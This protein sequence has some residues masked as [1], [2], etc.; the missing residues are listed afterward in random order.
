MEPFAQSDASCNSCTADGSAP[1]QRL[2]VLQVCDQ[3]HP[4]LI[5][6][7]VGHCLACD[8]EKAYEGMRVRLAHTFSSSRPAGFV[9]PG[10]DD[11]RPFAKRTLPSATHS[12]DMTLASS[13]LGQHHGAASRCS[14]LGCMV[15][16]LC[17]LGYSAMDII[18]TLFKV[19]RNQQM[20]EFLKM[21]F[22]KVCP[23]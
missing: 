8:I 6:T 15:Q 19:V 9:S 1:V 11:N 5:K 12:A 14:G 20:E 23:G 16:A 21:E 18:T 4:G 22:I 10:A 13:A 3:P 17:D 2:W 7:I